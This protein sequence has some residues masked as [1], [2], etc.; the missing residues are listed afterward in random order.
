MLTILT[1]KIPKEAKKV[2][3]GIIFDVY[4]W[5]QKMFDGTYKTYELLKRPNT[6]E[7]IATKDDKI[8]IGYEK[9]PGIDSLFNF[10]GGKQEDNEDPLETA[11]R[12]LIEETGFESDDWEL[13]KTYNPEG[14]IDWTIYVFIA[15][16]CKK[17]K[18]TKLESGEDIEVK[19][20]NFKEFVDAVCS[21]K[22]WG[23]EI[24]NDFLRM[25]SDKNKLQ[26]FRKKI[27]LK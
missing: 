27:F 4:Q 9:Q 5:E 20:M 25:R 22:F 3:N 24:T 19:E 13:L 10:F 11:K 15:R 8:L 23:T 14:K 6:V 7:V 12:E 2:F 16:N 1:M 26:E 17:T 21:K 18:N